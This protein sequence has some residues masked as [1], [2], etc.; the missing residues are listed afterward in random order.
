MAIVSAPIAARADIF[1]RKELVKILRKAQTGSF[2]A[3][4]FEK[5]ATSTESALSCLIIF[6]A[7]SCL[8]FGAIMGPVGCSPPSKGLIAR[9]IHHCP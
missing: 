7:L 8:R 3:P 4:L 2:L 6:W 1:P 5:A 9:A